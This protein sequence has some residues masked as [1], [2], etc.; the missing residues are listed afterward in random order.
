MKRRIFLLVALVAVAAAGLYAGLA[1]RASSLALTGIVSTNEVR[2]SAQI[3][4]RLQKL[5]VHEGDTVRKGQLLA[6]IQP[7][8]WQADQV[9]YQNSQKASA[10]QVVQA[11]ADLEFQ[12]AQTREQIRQAKANLATARA[13]VDQAK[14]D[15]QYDRNNY[16]RTKALRAGNISSEQDY[17]QAYAT[18]EAAK[19]HLTS[20]R[21]Q[22]R[23]AQAALA[24]ARANAEQVAARRAAL[25]A[26]LGQLAAAGAQTEKADVLLGYTK[27]RS[28]I[29]GI[30]DVK[31]AL[32]GEVVTPGQA[33]V[34]LVNPDNL[35]VRADVE[36]TY[37]DRIRLGEKMTVRLPSGAT[38]EGT[39]F[40]RG[41]D[42][43]YA[44]QRDV[45]R[46]K[47]DIKTFQIRL[48]CDNRDRSLALGMT[49]TVLLPLR[50]G[51]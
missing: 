8:Q 46:T 36:E 27:I 10:A 50:G 20:L 24:L 9:F 43:D 7:Q 33:I 17:D 2:V 47:R 34:A 22:V 15:L 13:Q 4:G 12:Q 48:R 28:P 3:Q 40:F 21:E 26:S 30:V 16:H 39:V 44:T 5:L 51:A 25:K 37:I 31:A 38:R 41:V 14:A 42:A 18:F 6:V 49:A 45:S 19:A 35:W 29:N 11:K 32:Q 1:H 23:A